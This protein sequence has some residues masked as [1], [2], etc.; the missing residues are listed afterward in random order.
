MACQKVAAGGVIV[1]GQLTD[2]VLAEGFGRG[3]K[4]RGMK[5]GGSAAGMRPKKVG[6]A[7]CSQGW[8][9]C[10]PVGRP[11]GIRCGGFGCAIHAWIDLLRFGRGVQVA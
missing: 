11:L 1:L 8:L 10:P 7:F 2:P 5:G 9:L 6:S 4:T 3:Q